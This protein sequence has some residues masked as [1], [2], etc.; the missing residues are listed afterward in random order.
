[1][2]DSELVI[3]EL[4]TNAVTATGITEAEPRWSQLA[5]LATIYVRLLL[6]ERSIVIAVWDSSPAPPVLREPQPT[7]R[8]AVACPSSPRSVNDGTTC[9]ARAASAYALNWQYSRTP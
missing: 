5:S 1:V 6:F 7:A 4:A 3:S 2:Q 9:P 8:P